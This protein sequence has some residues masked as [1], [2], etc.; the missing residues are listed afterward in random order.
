MKVTHGSVCCSCDVSSFFF[1]FFHELVVV[2]T[3]YR[4]SSINMYYQQGPPPPPYYE[5]PPPPPPMDSSF[6][7]KDAESVQAGNQ[8]RFV[9]DTKY[10]DPAFIVLFVIALAGLGTKI[11]EEDSYFFTKQSL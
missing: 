6:Q 8:A 2:A 7:P 9:P 4:I 3:T 10:R 11:T 1:A 5:A